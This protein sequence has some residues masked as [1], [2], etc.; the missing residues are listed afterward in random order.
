[1]GHAIEVEQ[2]WHRLLVVV[3]LR[4]RNKILVILELRKVIMSF[5]N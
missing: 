4:E 1:M 2:I 5:F 3:R